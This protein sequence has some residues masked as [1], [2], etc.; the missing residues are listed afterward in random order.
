MPY[1]DES[2]LQLAYEVRTIISHYSLNTNIDSINSTQFKEIILSLK[3]LTRIVK[4]KEA[5]NHL[6]K[7]QRLKAAYDL[8]NVEDTD[9]WWSRVFERLLITVGENPTWGKFANLFYCFDIVK[10][11]AGQRFTENLRNKLEHQLTVYLIHEYQ[12][13]IKIKG[14]MDFVKAARIIE[15]SDYVE[16][17]SALLDNFNTGIT[18]FGQLLFVTLLCKII[19]DNQV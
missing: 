11:A 18:K 16:D 14:W 13:L 3:A 1:Y 15:E 7:I 19:F 4:K 9:D 5:E 17:V 2:I 8:S 12:V 6:W 10:V